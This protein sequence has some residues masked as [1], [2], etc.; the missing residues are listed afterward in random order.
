MDKR[1]IQLY[2]LKDETAKDFQATLKRV[3]EIGYTGV[4]FAGQFGGMN[5]KDLKAFLADLGLEALGCHTQ[6]G[7]IPNNLAYASELGVKYIIDP[8]Q[9]FNDYDAAMVWA[10]KFNEVGK[11]CKDVG[12]QFGYHNHRHEFLESPDGYLLE[13]IIKN[14][15]PDL[16]CIQLDVGW[17]AASGVDPVAFINKHAGRIQLIHVKE[18]DRVAGAEPFPD[19]SKYPVDANGRPQIP[20]DVLEKIL[21]QLKWNCATG[22]GIIDWAKVRDAAVAQGAEGFIIER[23]FDYAGDL[24]K[25]VQEDHDFLKAL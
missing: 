3:K 13:T 4:E 16:V 25:C 5:A 11:Q 2:S 8:L 10:E 6:T 12:I 7:A 18:T 17:T 19:M 15:D 24:W 22:K 23:E 1:Y 9:P 21:A 14:T 20:P